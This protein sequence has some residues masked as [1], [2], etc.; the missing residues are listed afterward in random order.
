MYLMPGSDLTLHQ[1]QWVHGP[2]SRV[3]LR[4]VSSR[5]SGSRLTASW[6]LP[7]KLS[8]EAGSNPKSSVDHSDQSETIKKPSF[9]FQ[10][11]T[12]IGVECH[13]DPIRVEKSWR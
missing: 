7:G 8:L 6:R 5:N 1:L 9:P 10:L 12:P 13:F 11:C 2:I 4:S 3:M